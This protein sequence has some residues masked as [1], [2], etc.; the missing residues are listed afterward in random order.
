MTVL[1]AYAGCKRAPAYPDQRF[2]SDHR[3]HW[4]TRAPAWVRRVENPEAEG[5]TM[6]LRGKD[7]TGHVAL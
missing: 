1:C 6:G 3:L 2:C 5:A 7:L 4:T